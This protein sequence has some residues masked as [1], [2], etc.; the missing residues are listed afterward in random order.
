M[1]KLTWRWS[2][3]PA[4]V[5]Q[6][7]EI[8]RELGIEFPDDFRSLVLERHGG[9]PS[10]QCVDFE[11]RREVVFLS[12][13]ALDRNDA[14]KMSI[15]DAVRALED[16][17]PNGVVPFGAHPGGDFFCFDYRSGEPTVCY[18]DHEIAAVDPSAAVTPVAASFGEFLRMLYSCP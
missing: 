17:L 11:D 5:S 18:W 6:L 2:L 1:R 7:V 16:R 14:K 15:L 3:P 12:L 13:L 8:E 4:D 10:S 9:R